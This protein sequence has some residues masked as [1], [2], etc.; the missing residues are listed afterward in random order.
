MKTGI[1]KINDER[2]EQLDIHGRTIEYDVEHNSEG[3]LSKAASILCIEDIDSIHPDPDEHCPDGWS[4]DLWIHMV[5]KP[6]EDR[7]IIAG[8]FMAAEIDRLRHSE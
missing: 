4:Y 3:Q 8:T 2:N 1:E 5:S 7:L 6:W